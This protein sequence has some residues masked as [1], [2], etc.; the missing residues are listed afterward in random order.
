M[1]F[2][3]STDEQSSALVKRISGWLALFGKRVDTV[4]SQLL[5]LTE[6]YRAREEMVKDL[7]QKIM[8]SDQEAER[9]GSENTD[10]RDQLTEMMASLNESHERYDGA[11]EDIKGLQAQIRELQSQ[12]ELD[13]DSVQHTQLAFS[14]DVQKLTERLE[15]AEKR[16]LE[17]AA[18]NAK[19]F[20][21]DSRGIAYLEA[22]CSHMR[23]LVDHLRLVNSKLIGD[24]KFANAQLASAKG[25]ENR[26]KIAQAQAE[27]YRA[28]VVELEADSRQRDESYLLSLRES[29]EAEMHR[30]QLHEEEIAEWMQKIA[31]LKVK[32]AANICTAYQKLFFSNRI[33]FLFF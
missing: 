18:E 5:F 16:T 17:L 19:L 3:K 33:C 2:R 14:G 22:E 30:Q 6:D 24:I 23:G 10:L 29:Q 15:N 27:R 21:S 26:L 32:A 7:H 1:Y 25:T 4:C 31:V 28:Q 9:I 8:D 13:K 12:I 20:A 11:V